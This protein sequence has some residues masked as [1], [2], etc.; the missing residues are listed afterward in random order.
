[1]SVRVYG[2]DCEWLA[3]GRRRASTAPDKIRGLSKAEGYVSGGGVGA[4]ARRLKKRPPRLLRQRS[5]SQ[6][7]GI[8]TTA[9]G[10][11]PPTVTL[12]AAQPPPMMLWQFA[13]AWR[14]GSYVLLRT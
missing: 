3:T 5:R 2:D 12:I 4:A 7:T 6:I 8:N 9:N 10:I 11:S 14:N 13:D 1:M